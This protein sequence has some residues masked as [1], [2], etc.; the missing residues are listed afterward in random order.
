MLNWK[1]FLPASIIVIVLA[2]AAYIKI[3]DSPSQTIPTPNSTPSTVKAAPANPLPTTPAA[4]ID[5]NIQASLDEASAFASIPDE[6]NL[7]D[8]ENI[9]NFDQASTISPN[10]I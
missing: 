5:T 6:I 8:T 1:F 2:L 4:I 3:P 7:T 10:E 9:Q